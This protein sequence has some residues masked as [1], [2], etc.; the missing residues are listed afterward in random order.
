MDKQRLWSTHHA[1]F[2]LY[3]HL[4]LVTKYRRRVLSE[5]MRDRARSIADQI[6]RAF[7]GELH[8][9]N[10]EADHVHLLVS[11]PPRVAPSTFV[12]NLKT[13]LSRRLRSEFPGLRGAYRGK[14]VLWSPSYFLVSAGGA[15][16][17]VLK[18]YIEHQGVEPKP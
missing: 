18:T 16:L 12:G 17:D 2:A 5:A 10:G 14:A 6:A 11:L 1:V 13:V 3:F 9:C 15:P 8:E 4:I 7:E